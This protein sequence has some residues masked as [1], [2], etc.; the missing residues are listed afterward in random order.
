MAFLHSELNNNVLL[1]T[2]DRP[3]ANAFN[4]E[5]IGELQNAFKQAARDSQ[6]RVIV[7]TGAGRVFGAGQDIEEIKVGG[8]T[9]SFRAHLQQTYNPLILQ[10]RQIEK[11]VLAAVNGPCAGASLGIAL[12]CDLRIAAE[13]AKFVVGF[14]GI[15]LAPDSGVSLLLPALIGLGRALEFTFSNQ[16]IS[17]EKALAWGLVNQVVLPENLMKTALATADEFSNGSASA[18]GLTKRAYNKAVLPNLEEVL[19]YEGHLQEIAGKR[20]EH[21]EGV[22]AFLDKRTPKFK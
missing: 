12:A 13:T 15:G 18:F 16:P 6:T 7:L 5:L 17:A 21:K 3:K 9:L 8:D 20:P 4:L 19:D 10:I 2:I 22:A 14:S 11:P 1:L